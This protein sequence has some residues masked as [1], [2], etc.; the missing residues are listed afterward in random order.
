MA[1]G[2]SCFPQTLKQGLLQVCQDRVLPGAWWLCA[3]CI[4]CRAGWC[5]QFGL[6][7]SQQW[8]PFGKPS[9]SWRDRWP[10]LWA[11]CK[12]CDKMSCHSKKKIAH[13]TPSDKM[14]FTLWCS[15]HLYGPWW[16][17]LWLHDSKP[18]CKL[19]CN[20]GSYLWGIVTLSSDFLHLPY[21]S[22]FPFWDKQ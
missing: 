1:S 20:P 12:T 5:A 16:T 7:T 6:Q 14:L 9:W 8:R 13:S 15:L 18:S 21:S 19:I 10:G 11:F 22:P 17:H 4:G 2:T 3:A